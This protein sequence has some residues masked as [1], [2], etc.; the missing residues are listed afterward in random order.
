MKRRTFSARN[1]YRLI[2][3]SAY[4]VKITSVYGHIR[5]YDDMQALCRGLLLIR[6]MI[7]FMLLSKSQL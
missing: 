7:L 2:S 6:V 4:V 5:R 1:L 3:R